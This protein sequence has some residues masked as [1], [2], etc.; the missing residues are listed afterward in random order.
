[1]SDDNNDVAIFEGLID[2]LLDPSNQTRNP[3]QR[4]G[5]GRG[6]QQPRS[7]AV[8]APSKSDGSSGRRRRRRR[9]GQQRPDRD[10]QAGPAST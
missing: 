9:G 5:Q 6:R 7:D 1:M 8:H 3:A 10:S 2:A 4:Q